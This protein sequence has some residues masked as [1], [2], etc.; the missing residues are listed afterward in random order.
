MP[1]TLTVD[2]AVRQRLKT[3]GTHGMTYNEILTRLMDEAEKGEFFAQLRK[4][5]RTADRS[6]WARLDELDEEFQPKARAR[7]ARAASKPAARTQAGRAR[8]AS[9][10]R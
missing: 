4:E 8:R 9:S 1:T 5:L 10:P 6:R 3:F 7:G 2:P